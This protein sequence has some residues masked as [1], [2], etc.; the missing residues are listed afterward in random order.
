[1]KYV[2]QRRSYLDGLHPTKNIDSI[3]LKLGFMARGKFSKSPALK[4]VLRYY[5]T[6]ALEH[7]VFR[8]SVLTLR[9]GTEERIREERLRGGGER[10][11]NL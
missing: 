6:R 4:S 9:G 2:A 11:T 3:L 1:M 10:Q 8:S 7:V 5:A